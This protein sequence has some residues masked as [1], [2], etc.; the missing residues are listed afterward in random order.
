MLLLNIVVDLKYSSML[1]NSY[2]VLTN[3]EVTV[4]PAVVLLKKLCAVFALAQEDLFSSRVDFGVLSY[5]IH[6]SFIHRPAV[7]FA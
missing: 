5:I 4:Y 3:H 6:T 1:Q 7:I 2:L